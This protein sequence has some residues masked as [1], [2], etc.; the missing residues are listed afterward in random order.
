MQ[1]DILVAILFVVIG[2]GLIAGEAY[3]QSIAY[4]YIPPAPQQQIIHTECPAPKTSVTVFPNGTKLY[5]VSLFECG[6]V[7]DSLSA[8]YYSA[9]NA[10]RAEALAWVS[11]VLDA[12]HVAELLYSV[13]MLYAVLRIMVRRLPVPRWSLPG[14]E[15]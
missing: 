6:F 4:R 5:K 15:G 7:S 1:R 14:I 10:A 3:F 2:F 11:A 9:A 8:I 12:F 13:I